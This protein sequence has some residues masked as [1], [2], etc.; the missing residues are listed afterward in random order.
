MQTA[1]IALPRYDY[2]ALL[3]LAFDLALLADLTDLNLHADHPRRGDGAT[4]GWNDASI[5]STDG[6]TYFSTS[7]SAHPC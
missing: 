7:P 3:S 5:G 1:W 2:T 6:K 4:L